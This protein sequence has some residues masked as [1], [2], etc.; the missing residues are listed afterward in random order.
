MEE[1]IKNKIYYKIFNKSFKNST[2][3][4]IKSDN[5]INIHNEIDSNNHN[6][7]AYSNATNML[8]LNQI[9]GA[10]VVN[11]DLITD[12]NI[13]PKADSAFTSKSSLLLTIR[14]ADCVPI[15]L[16]EKNGNMIG[17]AH[18]GWR[19]ARSNILE[20]LNRAMR[21]NGANNIVAIIGPSI[22]QKSYEIDDEFYKNF[23][24]ESKDNEIFF[25][26]ANRDAHYLFD[27]SGYVQNKLKN[28]NIEIVKIIEEDTYSISDKYPSYR[29]SCHIGE[30]YNQSILSTIL[31]K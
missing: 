8:I 5:N 17:A 7:L 9:H 20:N 18:C 23:V 31:I 6:I 19:G 30:I 14:T 28:L 16:S 1:L 29:R 27:L 4:Y 24:E 12:Y 3:A 26:P 22:A 13:M 25:I 10:D 11:A 2:H 21:N 15:L